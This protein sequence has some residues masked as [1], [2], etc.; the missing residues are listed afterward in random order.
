[1][2]TIKEMAKEYAEESWIATEGDKK[3]IALIFTECAEIIQKWISVE[4]EL[5]PPE[6]AVIV[7][8]D[9]SEEGEP[10]YFG[11]CEYAIAEVSSVTGEWR[12]DFPISHWRL[13]EIKN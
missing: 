7:K 4:D 10:P 3:A 2:K 6:T 9:E 12:T 1:M 8:Y 13:V 5:P 11:D